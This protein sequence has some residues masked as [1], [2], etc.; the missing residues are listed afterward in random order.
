MRYL[1]A[2]SFIILLLGCRKDDNSTV[3]CNA[4][5]DNAIECDAIEVASSVDG[6]IVNYYSDGITKESEGN[7]EDGVPVGFWKFYYP[8]ETLKKEGNFVDKKLDGFWKL[9]YESGNL[10]EEGNYHACV[11]TGHWNFYY[12][13]SGSAIESSGSFLNGRK[14]G[15]WNYFDTNGELISEQTCP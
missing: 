5:V 10:K 12:D 9:Y 3:D 4:N 8:D 15:M 14:D 2:T 6:F 13:Q 11:K 1:V 7:Y